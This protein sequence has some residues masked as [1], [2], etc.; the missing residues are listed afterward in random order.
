MTST[1]YIMPKPENLLLE[2][3]IQNA[4]KLYVSDIRSV[5]AR[6]REI[7]SCKLIKYYKTGNC[8]YLLYKFLDTMPYDNS[9]P[10]SS[11]TS[12]AEAAM[13]IHKIYE[14]GNIPQA[15]HLMYL[16]L[17]PFY[18][19]SV[20]AHNNTNQCLLR[21]SVLRKYVLYLSDYNQVIDTLYPKLRNDVFRYSIDLETKTLLEIIYSA[22]TVFNKNESEDC[23]DSLHK[24][25][26]QKNF[27]LLKEI[28]IDPFHFLWE[29]NHVKQ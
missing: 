17:E 24:E 2:Q 26:N 16:F 28:F 19:I 12:Y 3:R 27:S 22:F 29:E 4:R 20:A 7:G 21:S 8:A 6:F 5:E 14:S 25:T 18:N 9:S 15:V 1:K 13:R 10:I 23:T 11:I